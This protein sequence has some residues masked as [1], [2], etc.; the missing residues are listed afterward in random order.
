MDLE[1]LGNPSQISAPSRSHLE[2][3]GCSILREGEFISHHCTTKMNYD[4][5]VMS[6]IVNSDRNLVMK[7]LIAMLIGDVH[8]S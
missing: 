2:I 7:L 8:D 5:N 6:M 3:A 1:N 4:T